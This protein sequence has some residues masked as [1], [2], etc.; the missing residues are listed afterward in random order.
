MA[1]GL[2]AFEKCCKTTRFFYAQKRMAVRSKAM[3]P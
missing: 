2:I 3:R 1:S